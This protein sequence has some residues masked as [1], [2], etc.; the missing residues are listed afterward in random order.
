MQTD[1]SFQMVADRRHG[2]PTRYKCQSV[3]FGVCY[4]H[5]L[6]TDMTVEIF[7]ASLSIDDPND[8]L[9]VKLH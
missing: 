9:D 8:L 7:G 3:V 4:T 2:D 5:T 1:V 6:A